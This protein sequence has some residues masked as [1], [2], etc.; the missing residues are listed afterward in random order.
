MRKSIFNLM[1][2][3]MAAIVSI[4]F[5]SCGSDD[6]DNDKDTSPSTSSNQT[7]LIGTWRHDFGTNGGYN[8]KQFN[9]DNTG[10]SQEYDP[11]DGGL[12]RK[13][14]FTYQ[15][16]KNTNRI[17]TRESDGDQ[18]VYEVRELTQ[19]TLILYNTNESGSK[20]LVTYFKVQQ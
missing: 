17:Y 16:D 20:A 12:R 8:I 13:H 4:G 3:L 7:L 5:V 1:A 6:D 15:Y 9:S 11:N 10:Y 18:G 14:D 2:L 19:N